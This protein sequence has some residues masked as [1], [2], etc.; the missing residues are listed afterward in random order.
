MRMTL[1]PFLHVLTAGVCEDSIKTSPSTDFIIVLQATCIT[2]NK[3]GAKFASLHQ[4]TY[5]AGRG[6]HQEDD[7]RFAPSRVLHR[8]PSVKTL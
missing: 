2:E 8:T 3:T 6:E 1:G 7:I 4:I 5:T